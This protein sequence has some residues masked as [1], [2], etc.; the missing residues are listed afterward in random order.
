MGDCLECGEDFDWKEH[1]EFM[2]SEAAKMHCSYCGETFWYG[3]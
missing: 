2:G 1:K 3:V